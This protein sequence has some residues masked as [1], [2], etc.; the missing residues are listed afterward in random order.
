MARSASRPEGGTRGQ[1]QGP[2]EESGLAAR[3]PHGPAVDAIR[4]G[5]GSPGQDSSTIAHSPQAQRQ[6]PDLE[7]P[8]GLG[9][10]AIPFRDRA[11]RKADRDGARETGQPLRTASLPRPSVQRHTGLS[12][13]E[14][15][16]LDK[17]AKPGNKHAY[18]IIAVNTAGLESD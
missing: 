6:G 7:G 12:L 14:M 9:E 18:R 10:R 1:V 11:R 5:Y 15:T 2:S 3:R 17:E 16:Y 8:G 13:V 4:R